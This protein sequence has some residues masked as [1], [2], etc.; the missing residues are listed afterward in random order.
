MLLGES[1]V[2]KTNLLS[3]LSNDE[4]NEDF[5]ATIG[6]EFLTTVLEVP[7]IGR[8]VKAQIWDTAGQERFRSILSAY[9]RRARG[10]VL[11]FDAS[12]PEVGAAPAPASSLAV[13]AVQARSPPA[14][15][16]L[17]THDP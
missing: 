11:V 15:L 1:G 17:P 2:G 6:V 3:R 5:A 9:Y 7:D 13:T 8:R 16:A 14:C 4:F 10:A 12:R